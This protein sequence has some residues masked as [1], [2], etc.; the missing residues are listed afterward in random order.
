M[1]GGW[2]K[3]LLISIPHASM[4][5]DRIKGPAPSMVG[6]EE[7]TNCGEKTGSVG[8]EYYDFPMGQLGRRRDI[9]DGV[10]QQYVATMN[11]KGPS[12]W[13]YKLKVENGWD[14]EDPEAKPDANFSVHKM[15]ITENLHRLPK[16]YQE[17]LK[18]LWKNNP[19]EY[20]RL[21]RGLWVDAPT[22]EALFAGHFIPNLHVKG[23]AKR[24]IGLLPVKGF[25]III[26]YDLGQVW[27]CATFMQL[28]PL[29]DGR[30]FWIIFDEVDHL[31]EKIRYSL[32][33]KEILAKLDHWSRKMEYPFAAFHYAGDDSATQWRPGSGS[34]DTAEFEKEFNK[35]A[36]GQRKAKIVACE[37]GGGSIEARVMQIMEK[38]AQE[39]LHIS[40]TCKN[41]VQM[42]TLLE[43][44]PDNGMA[45]KPK[46]RYGHKLASISH[47]IFKMEMSGNRRPQVGTSTP[48]LLS[49]GVR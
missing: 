11:P 10:P 9:V 5:E 42:F 13:V 40:A 49:C 6:V 34:Y 21:V 22:G 48:T 12:N 16:G 30:L 8:R 45:P 44:A 17:R 18:K 1:H 38:L 33:A 39:E 19:T 23:D 26:G 37:R 35:A 2:S 47:P 3:L 43:S 24:G 36:K 25:P 7:L 15:P 46:S 4:V 28:I 41:A 14:D 20:D 32:M 29:K 31:G 27:N